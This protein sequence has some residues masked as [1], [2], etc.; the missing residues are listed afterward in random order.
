M[1]E[2]APKGFTSP[3]GAGRDGA[4][5]GTFKSLEAKVPYLK[6]LGITGVWLAGYCR[7]N[8][9]FFSIWSVYA[10]ERPDV[11]D[12]ELGSEADLK[13]L[14]SSLH[15]AGIK[16]FLDVV[17]HG[18]TYSAGSPNKKKIRRIRLSLT[19]PSSFSIKIIRT[20]NASASGLWRITTTAAPV[21][22]SGGRLRGSGTQL[23]LM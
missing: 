21:S 8:F 2:I 5:S 3:D 12:E 15:K 18:V 14:I 10:T 9:H 16:V 4:G 17:T 19:I 13:S 23:S 7:A 6:A 20:A 22:S 11:I 1:Y